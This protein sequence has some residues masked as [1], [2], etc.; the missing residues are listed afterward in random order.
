MPE[1]YA[2]VILLRRAKK[3]RKEHPGSNATA[4]IELEK[5]D[6]QSIMTVVL[7]RP[8]KMLF[9]EWLVALSC[10]YLALV[11]AIYYSRF[12]SFCLTTNDQFGFSTLSRRTTTA[13]SKV[14]PSA[15]SVRVTA[16]STSLLSPQ[17]TIFASSHFHNKSHGTNPGPFTNM[18][19]HSLLSMFYRS[20]TDSTLQLVFFQVYPLIY[21][22]IYS[23]SM[24]E[25][26]LTF[27]AI[28]VGSLMSMVFYLYFDK[29]YHDAV[30]RGA[31]WTKREE[32]RRL[33]LAC[34]AA[35]FLTIGM[36]WIG[37]TARPSVHWIVPTLGGIPFGFGFLLIFMGLTNYS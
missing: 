1:T 28:G 8:L 16:H 35:P 36:F 21:N 20:K 7:A 12:F 37:W 14:C 13:R 32:Y 23:F 9:T 18:W 24:G 10:L 15:T 3:I 11:Y 34:I 27:L 33:P 2:P 26:G 6:L 30:V 19:P 5:S 17:T 31:A 25:M 29:Y 4:P 22:G